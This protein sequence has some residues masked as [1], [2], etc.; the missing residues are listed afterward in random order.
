MGDIK[1]KRVLVRADLNVP[2]ENGKVEDAT[3]IERFAPTA[4]LLSEKGAKVIILTHFGRPKGAMPEFST[5]FLAPVLEKYVGRKVEFAP[6]C[7][8]PA[9]QKAIGKMQGGDILLLENVRFYPEEEKNDPNFAKE[10][11]SLGD[12][13]VNDAFSAAHRAHASTEGIT[14]YLPSYAGLLMEEEVDALTKALENPARPCIAIVAGSKVSTKISVLENIA[15]KVDC[16]AIGGAMANTF[17]LAQGHP[18]GASMAEPDMTDTARKIMANG[19]CE[20]LLPVDVVVAKE[21]KENAPN[22]TVGIDE[23][24]PDDKIFDIGQKTIA[25]FAEKIKASKTALMN[26]S[27]G[28]YEVKPFNTGTN[29][30]MDILAEETKAGRLTSIAGGGDTIASLNE[31][32]HIDDLTYVST[33][34][35]A[36]LEWLEGKTLPAIPPLVK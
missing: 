5:K 26:G 14:K 28:V 8:G 36:F 31:T 33:A 16:M 17:L 24:E 10:L 11:A 23:V 9:A 21:L 34:G 3:R 12:M 7:K 29:A 20:I 2:A 4:K 18:I 27:L 30:V 6:D 25:L 22:R 13:Y 15:A 19:K 35:G 32:G 1:G